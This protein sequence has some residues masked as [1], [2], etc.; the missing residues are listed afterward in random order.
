MDL[1]SKALA[2]FVARD[3]QLN[4]LQR[5]YASTVTAAV[6]TRTTAQP[7]LVRSGSNL[8]SAAFQAPFRMVLTSTVDSDR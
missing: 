3:I 8:M 7:I 2:R 6:A 5:P 1:Y 4:M